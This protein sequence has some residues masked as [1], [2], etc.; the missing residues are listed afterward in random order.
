MVHDTLVQYHLDAAAT[1]RRLAG[2]EP[3]PDIGSRLSDLRS[4]KTR[5][6]EILLRPPEE[7]EEET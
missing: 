7:E 4:I 1:N 6:P 2:L 3:D 5:V